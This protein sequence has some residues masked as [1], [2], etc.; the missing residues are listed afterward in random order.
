EKW[1]SENKA[2]RF[3][4]RLFFCPHLSANLHQNMARGRRCPR[5]TLNTRKGRRNEKAHRAT[6]LSKAS[7]SGALQR[8][9]PLPCVRCVPWANVAAAGLAGRSRATKTTRE[10]QADFL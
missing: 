1:G 4:R 5:N 10:E 8:G 7:R 9:L 2:E 6:T 3:L